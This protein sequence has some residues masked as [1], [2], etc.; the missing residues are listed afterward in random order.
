MQLDLLLGVLVSHALAFA[1]PLAAPNQPPHV[2]LKNAVQLTPAQITDVDRGQVITKQLSAADKPEIAAFGAVFVH[3]DKEALLTH[4]RDITDFRRAPSVLEIGRL[5]NPPRIEDFAGL[6]VDDA[7]LQAL[8]SCRPGDCDVKV[9][10]S[11]MDRLQREISW[12]SPDAKACATALLRQ[13]LTDLAAAY[14]KG[15]T[16][17]MTTYEDKNKPLDTAAEFN[18]V[19][20]AS[21]Y[22]VEYVPE[23]HRY[24]EDFPRAK[25]EGAED[26][27]YWMKDK[28]GPKPTVALYHATIWKDPRNPTRVVAS[29]KQFYA[30]HYFQAGLELMALVDAP[31]QKGFYLLDLFRARVDPPTGMLS[32]VLLGK[33]R[34]GLEQGVG[35]GLRRAKSMVE[36]N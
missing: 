18:K 30:S 3:A 35:E 10:R 27:F 21:P 5:S 28:F 19:L 16:P 32:G 25:L 2:F 4:L 29:F 17:E 24:I 13:M 15:G 22:L 9:A 34:G 20:S 1:T 26:L 8:R 12:S 33:I 36:G 7:D 6:T 11:V 14:M 31:G 23:F